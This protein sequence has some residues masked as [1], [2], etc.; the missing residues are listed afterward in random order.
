[1]RR[2]VGPFVSGA[3]AVGLLPSGLAP[4]S[5]GFGPPSGSVACAIRLGSLP[6]PTGARR[7][8]SLGPGPSPPCGAAAPGGA[9]AVPSRC[10]RL[11]SPSAWCGPACVRWPG[12]PGSSGSALRPFGS[13][14]GPLRGP[15]SPGLAAAPRWGLPSLLPG[16]APSRAPAAPAP[17]SQRLRRPP[18]WGCRPGAWSSWR[19]RSG[20]LAQGGRTEGSAFFN[21]IPVNK[22]CPLNEICTG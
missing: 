10:R 2:P 18:S 17:F 3:A 12:L 5:P 6:R 14:S 15:P 20:G 9:G 22:I 7:R 19:L 8:P 13:G 4:S 16:G 21:P 1:M 11:A